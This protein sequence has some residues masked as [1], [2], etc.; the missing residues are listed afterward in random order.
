MK[1][2]DSFIRLFDRFISTDGDN[3]VKKDIP[4]DE[5]FIS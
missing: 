5:T 1:K 4:I 2:D 3:E